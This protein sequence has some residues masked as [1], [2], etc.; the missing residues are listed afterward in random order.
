MFFE[1]YFRRHLLQ[2][3]VLEPPKE[4]FCPISADA[5]IEA[6]HLTKA[7]LPNV[8]VDE[9]LQTKSSFIYLFTFLSLF[10]LF[11]DFV[12]DML[13]ISKKVR[14]CFCVTQFNQDG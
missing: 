8:G 1:S 3:S 5:E 13:T 6:V 14:I 7:P 4:R 2:F 12:S 11:I 10:A 9:V